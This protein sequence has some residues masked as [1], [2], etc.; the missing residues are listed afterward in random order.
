ML[1]GNLAK[2][3]DLIG[4]P[5]LKQQEARIECGGL[6]IDFPKHGTRINCTPTS[7]H[8]RAAVI[9]TE[10]IM[11]QHPD[12]FLEV[13]PEGLP[14]LRKINHEIGLIPRK[15]LGTLPTYS[16]PER[17]AKAMSTWIKE[18]IDQEIIERKA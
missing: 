2:Y 13:I 12:V 1:V 5:F 6:T 3:D 7:G 11:S 17:W 8:I 15:D 9:T 18:K 10:D 16:I 4:M 14:P